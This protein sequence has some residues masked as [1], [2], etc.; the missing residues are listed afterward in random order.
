MGLIS[1]RIC[2][3]YYYYYYYCYYCYKQQT[4]V[5]VRNLL[6]WHR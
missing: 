2:L 4:P 5:T 3:D 1:Y 6:V